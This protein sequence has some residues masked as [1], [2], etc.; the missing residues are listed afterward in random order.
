[1]MHDPEVHF[2]IIPRYASNK[3]FAGEIFKDIGW[4]KTPDWPKANDIK[5]ETFEK[6]I[7]KL[8]SEF[9]K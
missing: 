4:P 1:M 7:K 5:K 9:K 8:K 2:H 6:L 3:K